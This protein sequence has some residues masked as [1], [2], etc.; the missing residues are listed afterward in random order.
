MILETSNNSD[1]MCLQGFNVKAFKDRFM[2]N[3]SEKEVISLI[4]LIL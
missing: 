3:L 1:L 2:E 4:N